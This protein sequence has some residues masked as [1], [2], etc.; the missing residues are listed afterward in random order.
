[1]TRVQTKLK[2]FFEE[3]GMQRAWIAK[4]IGINPKYFYQI[5]HGSFPMPQKYWLPLIL[6]TS[7]VVTLEDLLADYLGEDEGVKVQS[8]GD[9][10]S[11]IVSLK[12]LN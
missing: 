4:K 7:G 8:I 1:M 12:I 11:C 9:C 6:I 3:K 10:A 5:I 2:K